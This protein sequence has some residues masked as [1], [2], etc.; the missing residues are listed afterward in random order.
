[1]VLLG[2]GVVGVLDGR[3]VWEREVKDI[4]G[5]GEGGQ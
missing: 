2:G 5:T 3:A 1:L 4:V